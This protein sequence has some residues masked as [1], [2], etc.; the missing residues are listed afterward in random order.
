MIWIIRFL[1]VVFM[2]LLAVFAIYV[3]F[4]ITPVVFY[5]DAECLKQGYP[6]GE[7]TIGLERYCTNLAGSVTVRVDHQ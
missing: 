3:L 1:S 6:K 7:V 2:G 5:T 4:I